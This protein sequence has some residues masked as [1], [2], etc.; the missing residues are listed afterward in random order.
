MKQPGTHSY[1]FFYNFDDDGK[2]QKKEGN[3]MGSKDGPLGRR[4]RKVVS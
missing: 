3:K 4:G 1:L 2:N